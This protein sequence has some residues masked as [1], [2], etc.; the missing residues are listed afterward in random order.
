MTGTNLR[1]RKR[2]QNR[3]ATVRAAWEL[4]IERGYDHVTVSDICA[5]ADIAPRTFH[6]YFA[7][8]QDVVA[9]PVREMTGLVTDYVAGAP[10][11]ADDRAVMREA[12]TRLARHVVTNRELLA[13]LRTVVQD[14]THLRTCGLV[15]RTDTEPDIAGMLAA[16]HPGADPADWR[17][18]LLVACSTAAFRIWYEDFLPGELTDP[19]GHLRAVMDAAG[20]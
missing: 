19:M 14:S 9:E 13:A 3:V 18:R 20:T 15:I 16:R 6:R 1:D 12:M 10:P 2:E 8:K 5:A 7:G 17:R 11:E 4:F